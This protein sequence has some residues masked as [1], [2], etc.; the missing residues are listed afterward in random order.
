MAGGW[1]GVGGW[2]GGLGGVGGG[3]GYGGVGVW[4]GGLGSGWGPGAAGAGCRAAGAAAWGPDS[5]PS[6]GWPHRGCGTARRG[7]RRRRARA[8][9][10]TPAASAGGG[11][12]ARRAGT[13][14]VM[15]GVLGCSEAGQGGRRTQ[16][17]SPGSWRWEGGARAAGRRGAEPAHRPQGEK[18]RRMGENDVW[19]SSPLCSGMRGRSCTEGGRGGHGLR[20]VV[21]G[22]SSP[23]H[24]PAQAPP[25]PLV[26]HPGRTSPSA[27]STHTRLLQPRTATT[28]RPRG[29]AAA[30]GAHATSCTALPWCTLG[31]EGE[32]QAPWV[33]GLRRGAL[34]AAASEPRHPPSPYAPGAPPPAACP[35]R[36]W[37]R[38]PCWHCRRLSPA[39]AGSRSGRSSPSRPR[40]CPRGQ[41]RRAPRTWHVAARP[42]AERLSPR[43][44]R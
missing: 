3:V 41:T 21:R 39:A 11:R 25:C 36:R 37:C 2:G 38:R 28:T 35:R 4:G 29:P 9:S 16:G 7:G 44:A 8:T 43:R 19:S 10:R 15:G 30:A 13:L 20:R 14:G 23:C 17:P 42:R 26:P 40:Y 32:G 27:P 6:P 31:R 12:R 22:R 5:P 18:A 33:P 34:R 1:G 24:P